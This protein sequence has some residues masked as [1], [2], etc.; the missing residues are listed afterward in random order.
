LYL[1]SPSGGP[2]FYGFDLKHNIGQFIPYSVAHPGD[3]FS[4]DEISVINRR[5]NDLEYHVSLLKTRTADIDPRALSKLE[6]LLPDLMVVK[7]DKHGNSVIPADF[8]HALQDKI[9][10]DKTIFSDH[11]SKT[12]SIS[13]KEIEAIAGKEWAKF[14]KANKAKLGHLS[15]SDGTQYTHSEIVSK[16]DILE[17]IRQNWED[18]SKDIKSEMNQLTKKIEHTTRQISELQQEPQGLTA[19]EGRHIAEDAV[20]KFLPHAQLEA[21]AKSNL[22]GSANHGLT[23]LN[24]FSKGTGATIVPYLT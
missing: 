22:Q 1:L 16:K 8:W 11:G 7:K 15:G 5:L 20:K 9:R 10:S 19:K 2:H 23:Q 6:Q 18:N 13:I 21:L 12:T 3:Y 17:M 24:F 14:L 4:A